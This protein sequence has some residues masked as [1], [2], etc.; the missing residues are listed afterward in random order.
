MN[1][2]TRFLRK[3]FN[4]DSEISVS[5]NICAGDH[6]I[7]RIEVRLSE[8]YLYSLDSGDFLTDMGVETLMIK[9]KVYHMSFDS[10]ISHNKAT[11][12]TLLCETVNYSDFGNRS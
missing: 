6:V 1:W 9:R 5:I 12:A 8:S 11:R 4:L 2:F 10:Y 7:R 3:L